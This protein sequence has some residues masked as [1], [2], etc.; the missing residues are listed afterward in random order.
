MDD[1]KE[2]NKK[3][4]N[5][6]INKSTSTIG[7]P[8]YI[9]KEIDND[10]IS[11]NIKIS[12]NNNISIKDLK[13][14]DEN[15]GEVFSNNTF[16]ILTNRSFFKLKKAKSLYFNNEKKM[17]ND[18]TQKNNIEH[19]YNRNIYDNITN[20]YSFIPYFQTIKKN[21]IR[22]TLHSNLQ[23]L[24]NTIEKKNNNENKIIDINKEFIKSIREE[25][26]LMNLKSNL[27]NNKSVKNKEIFTFDTIKK[28]EKNKENMKKIFEISP[29]VYT[30][31]IK[32]KEQLP[33]VFKKINNSIEMNLTKSSKN[34]SVNLKYVLHLHNSTARKSL[35]QFKVKDYSIKKNIKLNHKSLYSFSKK[36]NNKIN[37][38]S[39]LSNNSSLHFFYN[40]L[41]NYKDFF[42]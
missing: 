15:N 20:N 26:K 22:N 40:P 5:I 23:N 30:K 18:L 6:K 34:R 36:K 39:N 7:S 41:I 42:L 2:Q 19:F 27:S 35:S 29:L 24:G 12:S 16:T 14:N 3:E 1:M 28:K 21:R 38:P 17:N 32:S 9:D 11:K 37:N 25:I 13:L 31:I 8:I 33:N 4:K 10:L